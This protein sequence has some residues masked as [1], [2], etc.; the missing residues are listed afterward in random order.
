LKTGK[1]TFYNEDGTVKRVDVYVN[2][3]KTGVDKDI[4]TKEQQDAEREKYRDFKIEDP[5]Q[6]N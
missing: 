3:K 4:I 6:G 5:S 2:G 1:W